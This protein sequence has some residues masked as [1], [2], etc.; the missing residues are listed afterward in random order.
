[1]SKPE[2]RFIIRESTGPFFAFELCERK[3]L[4]WIPYWRVVE[5]SD[6]VSYLV[7]RMNILS[8]L[9]RYFDEE[10]DAL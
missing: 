8:T 2:A 6:R 4:L 9:P 7:E 5:R 1:M 10:G 3:T